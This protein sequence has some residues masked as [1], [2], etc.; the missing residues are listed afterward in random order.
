MQHTAVSIRDDTVFGDI[1]TV[2]RMFTR[3]NGLELLPQSHES[4]GKYGH[5]AME[6]KARR[7]SLHKHC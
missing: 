4:M 3:E 5:C 2:K 1:F 6:S 7:I